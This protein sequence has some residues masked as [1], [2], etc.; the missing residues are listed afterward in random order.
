MKDLNNHFP[1]F[2]DIRQQNEDQINKQRENKNN[3]DNFFY[4][5]V[6]IKDYFKGFEVKASK[7]V[8][9]IKQYS[10][11]DLHPNKAQ[12]TPTDYQLFETD[13]DSERLNQYTNQFMTNY[14]TINDQTRTENPI[15]LL[16]F[17]KN[18]LS[19]KVVFKIIEQKMISRFVKSDGKSLKGMDKKME[20]IEL[21]RY[22]EK[23]MSLKKN[24]VSTKLT[25]AYQSF[26]LN[27]KDQQNQSGFTLDFLLFVFS[28]DE[29]QICFKEHLVELEAKPQQPFIL[30]GIALTRAICA[31]S[32]QNK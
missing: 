26:L 5:N 32:N 16:W 23:E 31:F 30:K 29:F 13:Q 17:N 10:F 20:R 2:S 14:L 22:L 27:I 7:A 11:N 9:E 8:E 21:Y 25:F 18:K 19:L 12:F 15:D 28:S 1:K 4:T 3:D 6:N 24:K